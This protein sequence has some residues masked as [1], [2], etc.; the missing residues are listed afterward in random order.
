M[1]TIR[2]TSRQL[3]TLIT[4]LLGE[5]DERDKGLYNEDELLDI[6]IIFEK[7]ADYLTPQEA[8]VLGL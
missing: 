1:A 3:K 6:E 2:L 5:L 7:L 4:I 8:D